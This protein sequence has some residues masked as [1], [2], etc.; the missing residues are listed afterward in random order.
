MYIPDTR[1]IILLLFDVCMFY[2]VCVNVSIFNEE[3]VSWGI[4][5]ILVLVTSVVPSTF[6]FLPVPVNICTSNLLLP[7]KILNQMI[8]E[9]NLCN[10][11]V[12]KES[13][14]PSDEIKNI[15]PFAIG[16]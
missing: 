8:A 4:G 6:C 2:F 7:Q 1:N 11:I 13:N 9:Q 3:Y 5:V 15:T 14:R 10:L 16:A 12:S